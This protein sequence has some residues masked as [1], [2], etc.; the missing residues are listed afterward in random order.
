MMID[1]AERYNINHPNLCQCLRWKGMFIG[2]PHD[3]SVP[4][5][6][7]GRFWCVYTQTCLGPDGQLAEPR[8]C[9]SEDRACYGKGHV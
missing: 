1:E 7:D 5:S 2:V 3:P 6:T 8:D 9:S 4:P